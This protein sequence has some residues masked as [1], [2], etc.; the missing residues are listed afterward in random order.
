MNKSSKHI[1]YLIN[2]L[3]YQSIKDRLI[4]QLSKTRGFKRL[5]VNETSAN[6]VIND[7][8][9][10]MALKSTSEMERIVIA[11]V[12]DSINKYDAPIFFDIGA[13]I[14]IYSILLAKANTK[15]EIVAFEPYPINAYRLLQNIKLND[16]DIDLF[17]IAI[18][19][20]EMPVHFSNSIFDFGDMN[21]D[22]TT[23]LTDSGNLYVYSKTLSSLIQQENLQIPNII[24]IDVEGAEGKV[25]RGLIPFIEDID[26]IYYEIHLHENGNSIY[27]YNDDIKDVHNIIDKNGFSREKMA[28]RSIT[29]MWKAVSM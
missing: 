28:D 24:K 4:F 12:I 21:A 23:K 15:A 8:S 14:G 11:D 3:N 18:S 16:A 19:N 5:T 29:Q 10:Y 13:N 6:F 25:L 1:R 26:I 22:P 7:I 2:G 27:E 17:E 9:D 20:K